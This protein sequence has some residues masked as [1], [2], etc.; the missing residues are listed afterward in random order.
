MESLIFTFV[1]RELLKQL[2]LRADLFVPN[3]LSKIYSAKEGF[4]IIFII[5]DFQVSKR[6]CN[7]ALIGARHF[8]LFQVQVL[9]PLPYSSCA[10]FCNVKMQLFMVEQTYIRGIATP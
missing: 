4:I 3:F 6:V 10:E 8:H 9:Y 7:D 2:Q 1:D 5:G